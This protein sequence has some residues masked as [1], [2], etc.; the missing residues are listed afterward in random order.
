MPS[1]KEQLEQARNHV[2]HAKQRVT[3]HTALIA[4]LVADGHDPIP[5]QRLLTTLLEVLDKLTHH[6]AEMERNPPS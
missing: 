1:L 4:K 2:E 3:D 6:L 5:A